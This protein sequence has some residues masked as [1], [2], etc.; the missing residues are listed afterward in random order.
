[1]WRTTISTGMLR[2]PSGYSFLSFS[3]HM[4]EKNVKVITV[5]DRRTPKQDAT[6]L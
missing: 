5:K 4:P 2:F 1:M 3:T 6:L